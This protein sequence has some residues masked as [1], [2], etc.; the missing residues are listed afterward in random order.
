MPKVMTLPMGGHDDGRDAHGVDVTDDLGVG[1]EDVL[2][3]HLMSGFFLASGRMPKMP[4][5]H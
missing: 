5:T 3:M 1:V 4:A 2:K